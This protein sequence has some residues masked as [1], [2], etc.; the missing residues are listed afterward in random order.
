MKRNSLGICLSGGGV[1]GAAHIGVLKALEENDIIPTHVSG[2]SAGSL[3][4]SLY[5]YGHSPLVIWKIVEETNILSLI[6]VRWGAGVMDLSKFTKILSDY[7]AQDSFE[8]FLKPMFIAISNLNS[9]ESEIVFSGSLFDAISAS[10]AVPFVFKPIQIG[11]AAY[12]DGGLLNNLPA[13]PLRYRCDKV[14][15]VN[16][17]PMRPLEKVSGYVD[18]TERTIDMII[19]ANTKPRKLM[20]DVVLDI[21]GI[22]KYPSYDITKLKPIY[23]LGYQFA[24]NKI[25]EIKALLD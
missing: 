6:K 3:I 20:C 24:S 2:A 12:V 22:E 11:N 19:H 23:E 21:E 18:L 14:I 15:G 16:V 9:G 4:G 7:F 13:E 1:R 25:D 10:C 8:G 17:H 5:A